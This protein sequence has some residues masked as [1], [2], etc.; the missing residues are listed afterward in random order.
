MSTTVARKR[1]KDPSK[2]LILDI[3]RLPGLARVWEPKTRYIAPRSFVEWPR[4]LCWDARWYGEKEHMFAAEW[5]DRDQMIRTIWDL[6]DQAEIVVS[7]NGIA[8]D[9]RHLRSEWLEAGLLPPRP[10]KDVDL[11]KVVKQFGFESKSLDSVSRR[12]GRP[13]KALSYD[14]DTAFAAVEGDRSRTRLRAQNRLQR[15]NRGD[16]EL[17]EWLYDRL[18]GWISNH[19]FIGEHD[20]EQTPRCNQC[21]STDLKNQ[22]S[23]YR[24]VVIDYNLYRCGQCGGLLRGSWHSRNT[25]TRGVA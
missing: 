4:L 25:T 21:G 18:R 14:A 13:G 7:Y 5:I 9:H 10:W 2:I 20:S 3:E 17:T 15:Y 22:P 6:Y 11:Y 16:V 24:A 12:L 1:I 19:P 23:K 8:F